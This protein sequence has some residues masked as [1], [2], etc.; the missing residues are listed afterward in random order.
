MKKFIA[1]VGVAILALLS[2]GSSVGAQAA[3]FFPTELTAQGQKAVQQIGDC[4]NSKR[5]LQVYYLIDGSGSLLNT[6]PENLRAEVLATSL[7]QLAPR[8]TSLKVS[9]AVGTFGSKF[10]P[11]RNDK[12][13]E[14]TQENAASE[15]DWFRKTIPGLV[16]EGNTNWQAGIEGAVKA[17]AAAKKKDPGA[18][19]VAVWLTDGGIDLGGSRTDYSQEATSLGKIC[20]ANPASGSNGG[21]ALINQLRSAKVNVIGVLLRNEEVMQDLYDNSRSEFNGLNSTM[22]FMLPIIEGNGGV[23]GSA[24]DYK[25]DSFRCGSTGSA[26][27][28]G[29]ELVASDALQ[30]GL[31]FARVVARSNNGA[32]TN[33]YG[34][35]PAHFKIDKGVAYFDALISSK[36]WK[37]VNPK[38]DVVSTPTSGIDASVSAG[39]YLVRV[40]IKSESDR[41]EWSIENT[42]HTQADVFLYSG[43]QMKVSVKNIEAGKPVGISGQV[44]DKAGNLADLSVYKSSTIEL[45]TFNSTA[46]VD[47]EVPLQL[48][49]ASGT[50]TGTFTPPKGMSRA[51]FDVSLALVTTSGTKLS[52]L[53]LQ[54]DARVA[55]PPEYPHIQGSGLELSTLQ[56][57]D[58]VA[59]GT[60][61]LEGSNLNDGQ[62]CLDAPII[63]IDPTP[64][65]IDGFVWSKAGK[66]CIN[67]PQGQV[68]EVQY[69]V[70][71]KKQS[72]GLTTGVIP[73]VF[74]ANVAGLEPIAQNVSLSFNSIMVVN[75]TIRWLF[76]A[77]LMLL[78]LLLPLAI[79]Y[80]FGWLNSRIMW[81]EGIQRVATPV[82]IAADGS[83]SRRDG[84][85]ADGIGPGSAKGE[86]DWSAQATER[87]RS[88]T[89]SYSDGINSGTIEVK[90]R[91]S[92]NPFGDPVVIATASAG[93]RLIS[94][95]GG[96]THGGR[97]GRMGVDIGQA[98][99][100]AIPESSI[101]NSENGPY[102]ATAIS[103]L[104][105]DASKGNAQATDRN[106]VIG[107]N[108]GLALIENIAA[109]VRNPAPT[110]KEK[111]ARKKKK[112]APNTE[113]VQ[114]VVNN[115]PFSGG[116]TRHGYSSSTD[117]PPAAP[118]APAT[119]YSA[120]T[121]PTPPAGGDSSNP[122]SGN[123]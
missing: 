22:S 92:R 85:P 8:D 25:A 66:G 99:F 12:W 108:S 101:I 77:A 50:F 71:N 62:V 72:T 93:T 45:T 119:P 69:E 109:D 39:A 87:V 60:L 122:F 111:K 120:P 75:E 68:V 16:K 110:G 44:V 84:K 73:G 33:V 105:H 121:D 103:Y 116:Y 11:L 102:E 95:L 56:G 80:F 104:R 113:S 89:D 27:A 63:N 59:E 42:R 24:F 46:G 41:G 90:G 81:G 117:L 21:D 10:R 31:Q 17:L 82:W 88:F 53:T 114:P 54:V 40:P 7:E 19:Q 14:V 107:S 58:A 52:P 36:N 48:N 30:L 35:N 51:T 83:L 112:A 123:Y 37:L 20:G 115:D 76:L 47:A 91:A 57:V 64:S 98:W 4:V 61:I 32:S 23:D 118:S 29:A 67:V 28:A 18:C 70:S 1:L 15:A 9:Y 5:D 3:A 6:D 86:Y 13:T 49:P 100:I 65:R 79:L 94:S 74:K 106:A 78:G 55:L 2:L 26:M 97:E 43:L 38:G 34:D 96:H